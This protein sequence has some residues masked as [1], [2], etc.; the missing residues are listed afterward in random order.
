MDRK[1]YSE[2]ITETDTHGGSSVGGIIKNGFEGTQC[3]S[4]FS[5]LKQDT[6]AKSYKI[7]DEISFFQKNRRTVS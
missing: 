6:V 2:H 7:G 5:S 4:E 3:K 1:L